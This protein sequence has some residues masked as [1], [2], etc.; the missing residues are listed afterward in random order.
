MSSQADFSRALLDSQLA[1][2][3]PLRQPN[4]QPA[5]ARFGIYRNNVVSS[6]VDAMVVGFPVVVALLGD[7]YFRALAAEFVRKHPPTSPVLS[8]YGEAFPR[9]LQQFEPL[10]SYPYLPDMAALELARRSSH[11]AADKTSIA[12]EQLAELGANDLMNIVPI[13]HPSLR[14]LESPWPVHEIWLAQQNIDAGHKADMS[15]GA[16]SVMV[17]RP[18]MQVQQYL[19]QPDQSAFAAAIDDNKTL[20]ELAAEVL[21]KFPESDFIALMVLMIQRGAIA[22]FALPE[23]AST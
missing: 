8:T 3:E 17:V 1:V 19:L 10:A 7:T 14:F 20:A 23:E 22:E 4:G 6:L 2:P 15:A 9:F 13:A 5:Q 18:A 16:Q 12:A 21:G 11:N